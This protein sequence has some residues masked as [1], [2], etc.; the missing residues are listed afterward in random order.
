M[1]E[2][3]AN[4]QVKLGVE[5]AVKSG[6]MGNMYNSLFQLDDL[7]VTG[8]SIGN[9]RGGTTSAAFLDR[10]RFLRGGLSSTGQVGTADGL[11]ETT[12]T[13]EISARGRYRPPP[14]EQL[15][16]GIEDSINRDPAG[17]K[18]GL[19]ERAGT[20][21]SGALPAVFATVESTGARHLTVK[22]ARAPTVVVMDS[23][24]G[25]FEEWATVP[26]VL[27]GAAIASLTLAF[28]GRRVLVR[29]VVKRKDR[30]GA[31]LA[32]GAGFEY[33]GKAD[34]RG[35][36]HE[37]D[38]EKAKDRSNYRSGGDDTWEGSSGD[39]DDEQKEW[40]RRD[41]D[42]TGNTAESGGRPGDEGRRKKRKK[43]KRTVS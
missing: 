34:A 33:E 9:M 26:L 27:L 15:G 12:I 8:G 14:F 25:S 29:R 19:E 16:S 28:V 17:L 40:G 10:R 22:A 30:F 7:V 3:F 5:E 21:G 37:H 36:G 4:S 41:T 35:Y 24:P 2:N 23:S 38:D 32:K 6:V 20:D 31:Y 1:P 18:R 13:Y 43:K 11:D 42:D 39:D